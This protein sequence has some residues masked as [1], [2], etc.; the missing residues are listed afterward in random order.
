VLDLS[1]EKPKIVR[2]GPVDKKKLLEILSI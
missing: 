2:I 1:K